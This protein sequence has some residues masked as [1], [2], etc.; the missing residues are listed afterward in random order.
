MENKKS[1]K[2]RLLHD[3]MERER[4]VDVEKLG[5]ELQ[6]P[7][8]EKLLDEFNRLCHLTDLSANEEKIWQGIQSGMKKKA[9]SMVGVYLKY[10][11]MFVL[12]LCVGVLGWKSLFQEKKS[13]VV[14]M[15]TLT[16]GNSSAYLLLSGGKRLDLSSLPKDTMLV[17]HGTKVQIDSS[18]QVSYVVKDQDNKKEIV[19]NT[20]IV[21]RAGEYNLLLA[22]GTRVWLNSE[23]E[24]R[25]PV[26][27]SGDR[28]EVYLKGEGYFEVARDAEKPFCVQ[29]DDVEIQV[30][31]TIFDVNAYQDRESVITTLVS[32]K[33]AVHSRK[34]GNF[35]EIKP[36]EQ[37]EV[38]DRV[39]TVKQVDVRKSIAWIEGKFYFDEMPL[40]NIMKQLARWY[41]IE[42]F[43]VAQELKSYEFT[44]LIRKDF[45]AERVFEIIEKT[46]QVKFHVKGRSVIVN[47]K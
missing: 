40:E 10:V 8:N 37:A 14:E 23:S 43:F 17:E 12:P 26:E 35:V 32:G 11:A 31:G 4:E 24:L 29:A 5:N 46:T 9:R 39:V 47:Y 16:P 34:G 36:G 42:V 30:L 45:S 21:P 41:N 38:Q 44:G 15:N 20:I 2:R 19:Y 18:G 33:V 7:G 22:D 3:F 1:D 25:Y 27:F 28:R 6:K 13:P